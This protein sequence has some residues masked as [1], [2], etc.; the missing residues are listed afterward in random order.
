[1]VYADAK[2]NVGPDGVTI[3]V[4]RNDLLNQARDQTPAAM[5]WQ[6]PQSAAPCYG[7]F[8][9]SVAF[10]YVMTMGGIP[11]MEARCKARSEV[12]YHYIDDSNGF[13]VNRIPRSLRSRTS[14][15]FTLDNRRGATLCEDAERENLYELSGGDPAGQ[16]CR[17][18]LYNG[19]PFEG[20]FALTT[21]MT[22]FKERYN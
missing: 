16:V 19:M 11:E 5:R 1:M 2:P 10:D 17:A 7:V 8:M 15:F 18:S 20:V 22:A 3:V 12:L 21:F 9:C 4:V 14:V 13:Y 6:S